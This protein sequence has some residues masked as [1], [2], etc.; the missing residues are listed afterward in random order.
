[1]D[2]EFVLLEEKDNIATII[3]N[4][5]EK[6]NA[7]AGNMRNELLEAVEKA[8]SDPGIRVIV[9]TGAGGKAFCSGG[10]VNERVA[11]T[12]KAVSPIAS[13]E[14]HTMSKI[15][16][17]INS[18]EKPFIAAVNGVA[19]GGGCNLA[20]SCDIRVASE[21]ARFGE[22][23]TR[24]GTHPD[25]GGIYLLPRLVGYAKA[26]ELLFSGEIIDAREA[27]TIGMVNKVVPHEDLMPATYKMAEKIVKSAPIPISFIK[28]GL[29][30]FHRMDLSQALDYEAYALEVCRRSED[31]KEGF[32]SFLDKREPVFKGR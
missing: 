4:R 29:Q 26:A 2:G 3:L 20:L 22:V 28:R 32:A 11:G 21:K 1:M 19:A 13:S 25:W 27:L 7:F 16:L 9:I 5:P 18:I 23:F 31:F 10:D 8:G 15:V 6:Y 14:R 12:S 24:R 17:A 30:S